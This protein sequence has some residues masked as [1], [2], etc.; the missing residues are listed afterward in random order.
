MPQPPAAAPPTVMV[1]HPVERTVTDY[2]EFT[3]R[4][5]AVDSVEVR[6]RVDGY[7]DSVHFKAGS[8]IKKGDVLFVIDQRPFVAELNR[9]KAQLAEAQAQYKQALTQIDDAEAAKISRRSR[10]RLCASQAC[11]Q[12]A[13][14]AKGGCDSGRLRLG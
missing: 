5:S 8:L 12:H 7:L 4:L 1:S 10:F 9:A 2:A 13:T 6:A 11:S 14:V 3:G